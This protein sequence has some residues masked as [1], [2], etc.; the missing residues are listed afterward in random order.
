MAGASRGYPD[1]LAGFVTLEGSGQ[2]PRSRGPRGPTSGTMRRM[3]LD[4]GTRRIGVALGDDAMGM[5]LPH[6]TI[7]VRSPPS[8]AHDVVALA[9]REEVVELVVGW[10]V[11][12]RGQAGK[13]TRRVEEFMAF[14]EKAAKKAGYPLTWVPWDER[15][16]TVSA[17]NALAEADV[18]GRRRKEAVDQIAA[19]HILQGHLDRRRLEAARQPNTAPAADDGN[20][21]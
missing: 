14:V 1:G 7:E 2:A 8:A 15:M 19:V 12:M 16:T 13:A 4:V 6:A 21:S 3:G 10:P 9:R 5:A 11:D 20:P 17:H 18:F